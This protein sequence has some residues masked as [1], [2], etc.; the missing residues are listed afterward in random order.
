MVWFGDLDTL[1]LLLGITALLCV[2]WAIKFFVSLWT[3]S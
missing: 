2:Y 1:K 3:G